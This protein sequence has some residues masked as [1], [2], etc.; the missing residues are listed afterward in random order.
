MPEKILKAVAYPSLLLFVPQLPA[1]INISVWV[2][3]MVYGLAFFSANPLIFI[4]GMVISHLAIAGQTAREPH[5]TTVVQAW[6]KTRRG[7]KNLIKEK[8]RK[9]VP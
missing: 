5:L 7:T 3:F 6:L 9:Y 2:L 8:T 4:I 1:M